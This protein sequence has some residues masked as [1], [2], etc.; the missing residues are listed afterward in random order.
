VSLGRVLAPVLLV[1]AIAVVTGCDGGSGGESTA[2]TA[3][4]LPT[5]AEPRPAPDPPAIENATAE[6][7]AACGYGPGLAPAPGTPEAMVLE[8]CLQALRG[9][10]DPLRARL[11]LVSAGITARA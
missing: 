4:P 6:A 10:P 5:S 3:G 1:G 7:L 8:E 2:G 9:Y 11:E